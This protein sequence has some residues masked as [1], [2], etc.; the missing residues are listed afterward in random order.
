M[1]NGVLVDVENLRD[2]FRVVRRFVTLY[3]QF[4][5]FI[6][7]HF[8]HLLCLLYTCCKGVTA[9]VRSAI[10][11]CGKKAAPIQLPQTSDITSVDVTVGENTTNHS[12]T[13]WISEIISDISSSEPT[14][15]QSVQDFPQ[16]ESYIKIDFQFETGT[17]T[18]FAYEEN[19][20]H[21]IEQPYQGIYKIDSQLYERLQET[22]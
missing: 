12:D 6:V 2:C 13:A 5:C 7:Q 10:V 3:Q 15:K 19:G 1:V 14:S 4:P 8:Y 9:F 22:N 17:S 18:I 20:K 21:Y 16:T 11:A